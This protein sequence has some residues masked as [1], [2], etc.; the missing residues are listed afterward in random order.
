VL[1]YARQS[2]RSRLIDFRL[3]FHLFFDFIIFDADTPPII[4][5]IH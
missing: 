3:I 5:I 4:L 1:C 2:R